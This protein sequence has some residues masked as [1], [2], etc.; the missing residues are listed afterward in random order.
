MHNLELI[1]VPYFKKGSKIHIKKKN[2]GKFTDYC[3]GKV[4]Q[5]CIDRAKKSKN[6]KLRK[7]ATFAENAR[8]WK[9]QEGGMIRKYQ[10]AG[11]LTAVNDIKRKVNKGVQMV[12]NFFTPESSHLKYTPELNEGDTY[13]N[14]IVIDKSRQHLYAYDDS[15]NLVFNTPVSTG[16]NPGN[17]EKEG[18]SKT[19]VG[20][21]KL[22]YYTNK[23]DPKIFGAKDFWGL[24]YG[25]GI[26]IHGDAGHPEDIGL[27][28]SHGCIRMP[29]DSLTSFKSKFKPKPGQQIYILNERGKY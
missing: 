15:G 23:A 20:K 21:Y 18:D 5:E 2:R 14:S 29:T 27:P 28:A 1:G 26:G 13:N 4:T 16:A 10:Q 24:S 6:P 7:R 17:K 25:H 12:K 3:N 8:A 19:P 9:H 22:S 11:V